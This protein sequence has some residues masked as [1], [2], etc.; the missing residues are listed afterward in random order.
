MAL[1]WADYAIIITILLS[2]VI[3]LVRGFVREA[4][5]LAS[6]ILALW[7]GL[8]FSSTL[9]TLLEAYI[10]TAPLRM[11]VAFFILFAI[12]LIL[13]AIINFVICQFV[14]KTGLSGTDRML[15]MVFGLGRGVLLVALLLLVAQL[16]S[17]PNDTWWTT[18]VLI[19]KFTGIVTWIQGFLPD[20][21]TVNTG[22]T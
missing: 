2:I 11:V 6:W 16:S 18:S 3:S 14:K 8:T 22:T 21:L 19:S 12:T 17:L 15:G 5:S 1:N 13:G 4:M 10:K 20:T 7:V 9:A